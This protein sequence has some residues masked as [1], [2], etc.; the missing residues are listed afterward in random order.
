MSRS[1]DILPHSTVEGRGSSREF[2][3]DSHSP[4]HFHTMA[5]RCAL[6]LRKLPIVTNIYATRQHSHAC[7]SLE[8]RPEPR[9][10]VKP[11]ASMVQVQ[12]NE[13]KTRVWV[14]ARFTSYWAA[15]INLRW[16]GF[17]VDV[18]LGCERKE[19]HTLRTRWSSSY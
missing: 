4:Q 15:P 5:K 17:I 1:E 8:R 10:I 19:G 6:F 18:S 16:G 7:L 14:N 3:Q 11:S 13:S 9:T 2:A 12:Y